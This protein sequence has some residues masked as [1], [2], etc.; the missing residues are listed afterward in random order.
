MASFGTVTEYED[1]DDWDDYI[2]RFDQ[3]CIANDI[4]DTDTIEKKK[5]LLLSVIG[6]HA[7]SVLSLHQRSTMKFVS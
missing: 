1:G 5:A 7:F 4:T 2:E 3:F 6:S